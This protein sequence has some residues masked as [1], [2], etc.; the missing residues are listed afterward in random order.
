M[1]HTLCSFRM[2]FNEYLHLFIF[3][4]L[5]MIPSHFICYLL[6][7]V[8]SII[9]ELGVVN[10]IP[11][12]SANASSSNQLCI[13]NGMP[14]INDRDGLASLPYSTSISMATALGQD[15]ILNELFRDDKD[16]ASNDCSDE[17]KVIQLLIRNCIFFLFRMKTYR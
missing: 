16:D 1:I 17:S 5:S 2:H 10:K 9:S 15:E 7:L 11:I 13:P 6:K 4:F 12:T 8:Y 3:R 14:S